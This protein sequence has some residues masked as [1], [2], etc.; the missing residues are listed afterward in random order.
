M[1]LRWL[2]LAAVVLATSCSTTF[3]AASPP[4]Q[5]IA[6]PPVPG[7]IKGQSPQDYLRTALSLIESQDLFASRLN[8]A[9]ER[10]AALSELERRPSYSAA[11]QALQGVLSDLGDKHGHVTNATAFQQ[12][13]DEPTDAVPTGRMLSY[14]IG[15]IT[16][17][18]VTAQ[19]NTPGAR[20]YASAGL[21]LVAKLAHSGAQRWVIDLRNDGGG[22]MYPMLLAIL[23]VIDERTMIS[24]RTATNNTTSVTEHDSALYLGTTLEMRSPQTPPPVTNRQTVAVL[25]G[26][27]TGSAG[28]ATLVSLLARPDTA[29][30]GQ[31][32]FGATT[33][34]SF[35]SLGDGNL[36]MFATSAYVDRAGHTYTGPIPPAHTAGSTITN[37]QTLPSAEAWLNRP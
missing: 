6:A 15:Y 7:A 36:L 23:P 13:I 24:F 33:V 27:D 18:G 8:W 17:P 14:H 29:T 12:Y 5:P 19:A 30:F 4:V 32:T 25:I 2:G 37:D 20:R 26:P 11:D 34:P 1:R 21:N 31:P 22:D 28:E 9:V 10:T 35:Y 16:L 3:P